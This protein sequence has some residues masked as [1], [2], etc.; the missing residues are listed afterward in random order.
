M[1]RVPSHGDAVCGYVR[2]FLV[3]HGSPI[4]DREVDAQPATRAIPTAA[5]E[6]V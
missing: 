5:A 4:E 6:R 1:G 2:L 3:I